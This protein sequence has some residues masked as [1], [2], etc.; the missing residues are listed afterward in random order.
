MKPT[1]REKQVKTIQGIQQKLKGYLLWKKCK[2]K[3]F[4]FKRS[5][6][7]RHLFHLEVIIDT[8]KEA[9]IARKATKLFKLY[10]RILKYEYNETPKTTPHKFNK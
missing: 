4:F 3:A 5:D 6:L 10:Q 1:L 9:K 8:T 7:D 2:S